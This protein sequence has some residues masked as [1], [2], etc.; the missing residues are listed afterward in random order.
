MLQTAFL[1][2]KKSNIF[3]GGLPPDPPRQPHAFGLLTPLAT[4][5]IEIRLS[6]LLINSSIL[7]L[8]GLYI[9]IIINV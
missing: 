3:L 7:S 2:V 4:P 9:T 8:G 1:G 6:V 5:L